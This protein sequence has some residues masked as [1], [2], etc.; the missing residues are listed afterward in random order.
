[1]IRIPYQLRSPEFRFALAGKDCK[2]PIEPK[3]NSTN[4]YP[5]FHSRFADY[6]GNYIVVLGHGSLICLDFDSLEYYNS[7][8]YSLPDTFTVRTALKK[9][10]HLYYLLDGEMF[11]KVGIDAFIFHDEK[12]NTRVLE[13]G[14]DKQLL[15]KGLKEGWITKKRVC[16]I[17]AEGAGV[18]GPNSHI[19]RQFYDVVNDVP[20]AHITIEQLKAI[21]PFEAK[22]KEWKEHDSKPNPEAVKVA[23]N[24]LERIGLKRNAERH[25]NCIFHTSEGGKCLWVTPQASLWCFH[26]NRGWRDVHQF[27]DEAIERGLIK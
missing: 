24:G 10:P 25:F 4:C 17:Q 13:E 1:M 7:V 20:I 26:E 8:K 18:V 23:L 27:I 22:K 14:F 6:S 3:W 12:N 16:D 9:L 11:R 21:F 19:G 5:F 2:L 15:E